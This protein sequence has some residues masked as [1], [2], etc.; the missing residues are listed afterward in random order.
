MNVLAFILYHHSIFVLLFWPYSF[1]SANNGPTWKNKGT[2]ATDL[3]TGWGA[4]RYHQIRA[5]ALSQLVRMPY[6]RILG[7][8]PGADPEHAGWII[9]ST[10]R[11]G[12]EDDKKKRVH[13]WMWRKSEPGEENPPVLFSNL[14]IMS[15]HLFMHN[16]DNGFKIYIYIF[17]LTYCGVNNV[18]F[19][20]NV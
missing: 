1:Y 19:L 15:Y 6:G 13:S 2:E 3:K 11:A 4:V 12:W 20:R 17:L 8:N 10:L 14:G 16:H 18:N 9:S 7:K 5:T